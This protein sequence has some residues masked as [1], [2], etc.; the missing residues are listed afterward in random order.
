MYIV[1][2]KQIIFMVCGKLIK[3]IDWDL[4][5]KNTNYNKDTICKLSYHGS[6]THQSPLILK[7][8]R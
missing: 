2:L 7:N 5:V 4:A 6:A 8:Y 1:I 3:L